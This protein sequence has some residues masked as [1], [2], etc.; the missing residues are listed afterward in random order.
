MSPLGPEGYFITGEKKKTIGIKMKIGR[1]GILGENSR[2][3][4][5]IG[6][7]GRK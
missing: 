2:E 4:E 5:I 6:I 3:I 7:V 1:K